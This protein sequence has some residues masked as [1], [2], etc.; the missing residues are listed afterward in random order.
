ML[1]LYHAKKSAVEASKFICDIY[2]DILDV[3][4][5]QRWFKKFQSGNLNLEDEPRSG[6]RSQVDEA[7]LRA[8]IEANPMLTIDELSQKVGTSR[9]NT[10]RYLKK[11]GKV[12]REGI[13]VPHALTDRNK[14]QRLSICK[15]LQEKQQCDPFLCDLITGDEKWVLYNNVIKKKNWLSPGQTP[16][17]TPKPGLHPRK[18][19]LCVWWDKKGVIYHEVLKQGQTVNA[20]VYCEQMDRLNEKIREKRPALINR[21]KVIIHHDNARPHVADVTR[22]KIQDLGWD[23]M[24]HPAYSPD[25]APTD[26]HLFRSLASYTRGK[27]YDNIEEVKTGLLEFFD[28]KPA[29]FYEKGI[30]DL[31][32]RWQKV[33]DN[34]GNY[35]V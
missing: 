23:V 22:K 5:C 19:L 9:S 6:R 30:L 20:A 2:G 8:E 15:I 13:W 18:A 16:I 12:Q 33:I 29:S 1:L 4:K 17:L 35:F 14:A 32:N 21:R 24:L 10:H 3:R 28:S 25:L 34:C 7:S 11:M 27:K 26:Y 31:T